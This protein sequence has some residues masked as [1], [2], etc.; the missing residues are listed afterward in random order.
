[1]RAAFQRDT[2]IELFPPHIIANLR[3]KWIFV[4]FIVAEDWR[5]NTDST[6]YLRNTNISRTS[7][8]YRLFS[9][10]YIFKPIHTKELTFTKS[11][12]KDFFVLERLPRQTSNVILTWRKDQ[13]FYA[14]RGIWFDTRVSALSLKGYPTR[15][16]NVPRICMPR[17]PFE[18]HSRDPLK[19]IAHRPANLVNRRTW[20]TG[21]SETSNVERDLYGLTLHRSSAEKRL[22]EVA[23][24]CHKT[25]AIID[26]AVPYRSID[27][28]L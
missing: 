23:Q 13:I 20:N 25:A 6:C 22:A 3:G 27:T 7:R 2:L 5:S 18:Q 17:C 19:Q 1:M 8:D 14:E 11:N 10:N 12:S 28:V 9:T 24:L 21:K 15:L 16:K 4:H 26:N